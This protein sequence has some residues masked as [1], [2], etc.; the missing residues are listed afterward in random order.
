L[1]LL[2]KAQRNAKECIPSFHFVEDTERS[3]DGWDHFTKA[4]GRIMKAY[5]LRDKEAEEEV[6]KAKKAK[7]QGQW[8]RGSW[9]RQANGGLKW[10]RPK[11]IPGPAA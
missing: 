6:K 10:I 11:F 2:T 9:E 8:I 4:K 1:N 3:P 7:N 5:I